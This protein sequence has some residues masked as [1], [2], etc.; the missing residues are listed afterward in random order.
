MKSLNNQAH[1]QELLDRLR[2]ITPQNQR[3]WGSMTS[4]QMICHLNDSFKLAMGDRAVSAKTNIF[5]RT[6]MKWVAF[7]VP[8]KWPKGF[9]TL[10]EI[11]QQIGG[12][13][14]VDFEKD[15]TELKCLLDRFAQKERRFEWTVHPIFGKM[16][17]KEW[18]RWGYL[19][20]DHHLRQFGA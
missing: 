16:T 20:M 14:P 15:L 2:N 19:H 1:K 6:I 17:E 7:K 9:R 18:L 12:T 13:K 8:V 3:Q 4:H 10:P 11:D 5:T